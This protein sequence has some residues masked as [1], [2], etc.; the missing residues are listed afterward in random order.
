MGPEV[1]VP[2]FGMLTG[3]TVIGTMTYGLVRIA[4]S[5]AEGR[6]AVAG[7]DP[8]LIAAVEALRDQVDQLQHQVAETQE[9]L[10]FTERLLAQGRAPDRLPG[11]G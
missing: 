8:D 7:A 10:D 11:G 4:H 1:V 5:W 6:K 9:R 2:V 3:I